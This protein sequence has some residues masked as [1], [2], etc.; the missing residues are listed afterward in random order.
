MTGHLQVA[1]LLKYFSIILSNIPCSCYSLILITDL[2]FSHHISVQ[3]KFWAL[4]Y[5]FIIL[6]LFM[7]TVSD[8]SILSIKK[9]NQTSTVPYH[10]VFLC[11]NINYVHQNPTLT[12]NNEICYEF[13]GIVRIKTKQTRIVSLLVRC[14]LYISEMNHVNMQSFWLASLHRLDFHTLTGII[15]HIRDE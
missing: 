10:H 13:A 11:Q 14:L 12:E 9:I 4:T 1:A 7:L 8:W 15:T 3:F 6:P 2:I 5:T